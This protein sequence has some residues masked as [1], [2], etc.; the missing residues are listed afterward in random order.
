MRRAGHCDA[1]KAKRWCWT[2]DHG[3]GV[4]LRIRTVS[5]PLAASGFCSLLVFNKVG[6]SSSAFLP[7]AGHGFWVQVKNNSSESFHARDKGTR[8]RTDLR[9][10][11]LSRATFWKQR[12]V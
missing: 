2:R 9:V 4:L 1:E 11:S 7:S 5:D 10:R 8:Q 3:E 12:V 6:S